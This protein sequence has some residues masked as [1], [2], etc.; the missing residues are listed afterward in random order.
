MKISFNLKVNGG[1][2]TPVEVECYPTGVNEKVMVFANGKWISDKHIAEY[3][4]VTLSSALRGLQNKAE[5][6]GGKA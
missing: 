6:R 1:K 4:R 2:R 5:E 3:V